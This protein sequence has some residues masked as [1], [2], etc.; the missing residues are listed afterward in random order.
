MRAPHICVFRDRS[1][2]WRF[3]IVSANGQIVAQSEAYTRKRDAMRAA[4]RLPDIISAAR[5]LVK[6]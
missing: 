4:K 6:Q 1:S 3:R 5:L 2:A